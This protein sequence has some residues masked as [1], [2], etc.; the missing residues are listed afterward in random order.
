MSSLRRTPYFRREK[1]LHWGVQT[2]SET[3]GERRLLLLK[4]RARLGPTS[5]VLECYD[6]VPA[7]A[8]VC[9]RP[10]PSSL[11]E[12]VALRVPV[13]AGVSFMLM[14]HADD[15]PRVPPIAG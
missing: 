1:T 7:R 11:I 14:L 5:A 9:G 4:G 15:G 12:T 3:K 13:A 10:P 2:V 8:T 6:P